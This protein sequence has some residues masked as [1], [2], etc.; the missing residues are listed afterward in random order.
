[1]YRS[2]APKLTY[3]HPS[4]HYSHMWRLSCKWNREAFITR[5]H[6][7]FVQKCIFKLPQNLEKIDFLYSQSEF[8]VLV[9]P[10]SVCWIP[11][12]LG[13]VSQLLLNTSTRFVKLGMYVHTFLPLVTIVSEIH[14]PQNRE[15]KVKIWSSR[16][17]VEIAITHVEYQ[18]KRNLN[19]KLNIVFIRWH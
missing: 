17:F 12:S 1:M 9:L 13:Y 10:F 6:W 14:L 16:V 11:L 3:I 15:R 8:K 5:S 19:H 4:R 18:I 2:P 7:R